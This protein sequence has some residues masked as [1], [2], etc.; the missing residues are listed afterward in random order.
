MIPT[1]ECLSRVERENSI[2]ALKDLLEFS[3][4]RVA[5]SWIGWR[6]PGRWPPSSDGVDDNRAAEIP[7]NEHG[8]F[9]EDGFGCRRSDTSFGE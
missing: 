7:V 6:L 3:L 9:P 4:H 2:R 5:T 1:Q 8:D